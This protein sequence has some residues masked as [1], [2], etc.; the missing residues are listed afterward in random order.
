MSDPSII[1]NP[2]QGQGQGEEDEV[3]QVSSPLP[4]PPPAEPDSIDLGVGDIIQIIAPSNLAINEQIYLITYL[5]EDKIKLINAATTATMVLTMSPKGG[6]SDES[7]T[8]I[9]ILNSPEHPGYALQNGLTIGT[10]ISIQFG[11]DLPTIITGQIIN[12]E[13]DMIGIKTYPGDQ[14]FYIDFAYKGIPENIPIETI[15]I[16][17]PPSTKPIDEIVAAD[18]RGLR[19]GQAVAQPH[20][21]DVD[22]EAI[23]IGKISRVPSISPQLPVEE[24]QSALKEILI[25]ADSIQFGDELEPIAQVVELPDEQKRYSIEKQSTDLLNELVSEFP[26]VERTKSVLNNIHVIIE[27][28]RQLRDEF[29][30]FDMNGNATMPA[31]KSDHYKPLASTLMTLNQK[32]FWILPI[33]KNI[34]K[35]YNV[36]SA[37]GRSDLTDF[38]TNDMEEN[39]EEY[40]T[41]TQEYYTNKDS[42]VSYIG[43]MNEYFTP[44]TTPDTVTTQFIKSNITAVLDNLGDFY[45]SIVRGDKIKR[46]RFIIQSYNLGLNQIQVK[47]VKSFGKRVADL[48]EV[49]PLTKNDKISVQSFISLPEPVMNF[50]NISLPDTNILRRS[51]MDR[52][53]IPYWDLLR[54]NTSITQ[55]TISLE[56]SE[57]RHSEYTDQDISQFASNFMVFLADQELDSDEKYKQFIER[58]IPDTELLFDIMNKYVTGEITLSNYVSVLQPFMVYIRDLTYRQYNLVVSMIDQQILDYK[59]KY[60]QS[61]K[62]YSI[63]SVTKYAVKYASSSALYALLKDSKQTEFDTNILELYGLSPENY[64]QNVSAVGASVGAS[65]G[66][67]A[68]GNASAGSRENVGESIFPKIMFSNDEILYRLICVDNARL[69][70]NTLAIL[71]RDLV[72]PFDFDELYNQEKDKFDEN[73]KDNRDKNKCKNYVL[74]KKYTDIQD[75]MQ[76]EGDE[77]YYDKLYD[78]TDYP[79]LEKHKDEREKYSPSDFETFLVT[80]YMKKTKL[81]M[82][83]AKSEIRDMLRGSRQVQDGQYAVLEIDSGEFVPSGAAAAAAGSEEENSGTRYEYYIRVNKKWVKDDTIPPTVSLYD[84]AYFCNV[85]SDCF[86][87]NKKCMTPDLAEDMMK[88]EIIKKMYDEFDSRFHESRKQIIERVYKKYDYSFDIITR[89][90]SIQKYNVYK[91]NNSHYL[92]G[93]DIDSTSKQPLSPYAHIFDLILGQTDYVK[94]QRNIMRFIQKFTRKAI[95]VSISMTNIASSEPE[96]PYW[97]YCKQTDTKLVPSFFETIATVFLNQGDV[98]T[99]IDTICAERGSISEDGDAWTDKYSGYVIKNID[100]DSEEGFDAAGNKLKTRDVIEKTVGESLIQ[101]L[102]DAKIPRYSNPDSQMMSGIVTT[103]AKYLGIDLDAQRTFIV[104]NASRFMHSS[105]PTEEAYR[106]TAASASASSSKKKPYRE[107]KMLTILMITLSYIIITIQVSI[108]SIKTRKTFP[109]CVRSFVGYPLDGDGDY[110]MLK[111]IGCIALKMSS[112]VEPWNSIKTIKTV[113]KFNVQIKK[114]MDT[115]VLTNSTVQTRISEKIEYN[116]IHVAEELPAEHDIKLW[117]NFLPPLSSIKIPSPM[118]LSENFK[119]DIMEEIS[120]GLPTQLERISAIRSKIIYYSLAIQVMIQKVVSSEKLILTNGANE[121]FVENACCNTGG[122]ISTI[123]YFVER[124]SDIVTYDTYVA[125]LRDIMHDIIELQKTASLLDPSNTRT[126]YPVIPNT[127]TEDTIYLAFITYCKF[128]SDLPVPENISHMCHVKPAHS[129]YDPSEESLIKRIARLKQSGEYNYTDENLQALLQVINRGNIIPFNFNPS[130]ISYI[131]QMRDL[132]DSCQKLSTPDCK[133][134]PD[135]LTALLLGAMDTF[136]VQIEE[137]TQEIRDLKNYLAESNTAMVGEIVEFISSQKRLDD[138]T[139]RRYKNFLSTLAKFRLIGDGVLCPRKDTSTYKG[140][141]YIINQIRNLIEVFPNI[142][143]NGVNFQKIS[144]SKHWALSKG[145]VGDIQNIV[146][147]YY[148]KLDKF[149]KDDFDMLNGLLSEIQSKTKMWYQFAL[150]TPLFARMIDVIDIVDDDE[151]I[152]LGIEGS[153]LVF[154]RIFELEGESASTQQSRGRKQKQQEEEQRQARSRPAVA[155]VKIQEKTGKYSIFND[156]VVRYLFT[157]YLLNVLL[158]YVNLA[159]EPVVQMQEVPGLGERD[160]EMMSVLEARD[161]QNG[162]EAI[163]EMRVVASENLEVKRNVAELLIS[164]IEIMSN[165]KDAINVTRKTIKEDITQSKDKEKD[166]IVRELGEM[167]IDE[168]E[169]EHMKKNLRIGDWNVAGTKGLRFYVPETYDQDREQ[170]EAEF[171]REE[172]R[173][174]LENRVNKN[175]KVTQRVKDIYMTEEEE[176]QHEDNMVEEELM[177]DFRMQG[178]DDE[179]GGENEDGEH[180]QRGDFDD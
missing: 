128:N 152:E 171:Q 27:R 17:S 115:Y 109:G 36:D 60:I 140:I 70:M 78:F 64:M 7:I 100:L 53:F 131:Q 24:V 95:E 164:Y 119:R 63:L 2:G 153:D 91:Y 113:D 18:S 99:T 175:D 83:D 177:D 172:A 34:R 82:Q 90:K 147:R 10:W 137:D 58:L 162:V 104:E 125:Y 40:N 86:S 33:A 142:I 176:K 108:P 69:Y 21:E 88:D 94:R 111:Y 158:K 143:T 169:V 59:K 23:N 62:E 149:L 93:V 129:L 61:A 107:F 66:L 4:L 26:N 80:R 65:V 130:E 41:M 19:P 57:K 96:S 92:M 102:Q 56:E 168:R 85:K 81:P 106:G 148:S 144:V 117:I 174:K 30:E 8:S 73:M 170:M 51:N 77:V 121:P 159:K 32:L 74:T 134:I 127:F 38:T 75:L 9:V 71:N 15:T 13:E 101:S 52:N 12:L 141:Q 76:D 48:T 126:V 110:S 156:E 135:V 47:K 37:R 98:Q 45:S 89:I 11:G 39:I 122:S 25:D 145:H 173:A 35:F 67:G 116:K 42:F 31:H 157:H 3:E 6:F 46:Q 87:I 20:E 146:K 5:D 68:S 163:S 97:L 29:S 166:T 50:S 154:E 49:I 180:D 44:F 178:D 155:S 123:K 160:F 167:Q 114:I 179:I 1:E 79:F 54:K 16:R 55:K 43:K 112:G 138:K 22:I 139:K 84:T 132:I 14:I 151:E 161:Q 118:P 133:E 28:F 72:T 150:H 103:M 124:E 105:F 120:K 165:D 136:D